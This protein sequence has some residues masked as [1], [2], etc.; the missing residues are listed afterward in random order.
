MDIIVLKPPQN[1]A[2]V[3]Q[4][5]NQV[6]RDFEARYVVTV[7]D[8][9]VHTATVDNLFSSS[10]QKPTI[11]MIEK[12][13][14][15]EVLDIIEHRL[16][17]ICDNPEVD[18]LSSLQSKEYIIARRLK[19][20]STRT[21]SVEEVDARKKAAQQVYVPPHRRVTASTASGSGPTSLL[22]G[23]EKSDNSDLPGLP[24]FRR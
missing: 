20:I 7:S 11:A 5:A 8:F 21:Q 23:Q 4:M 24:P 13:R 22:I 17:L 6:L 9:E 2:E 18:Y 3:L 10:I 14:R 16:A 1:I 15:A 12:K 19:V